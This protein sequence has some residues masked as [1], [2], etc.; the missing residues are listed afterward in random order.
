MTKIYMYYIHI[1]IHTWI[2]IH[3]WVTETKFNALSLF[4]LCS[5]VVESEVMRSFGKTRKCRVKNTSKNI[6]SHENKT[7]GNVHNITDVAIEWFADSKMKLDQDEC[8]FLFW[9]M[10]RKS[11][12]FDWAN[13]KQKHLPVEIHT[14]SI[15][16]EQSFL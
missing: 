7:R 5:C 6:R 1:Y 2:Y 11:M 4:Q 8:R 9:V 10:T 16:E 13:L 14:S 12:R 15:F 3:P